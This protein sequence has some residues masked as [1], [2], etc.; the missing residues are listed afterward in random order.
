MLL[1]APC[2]FITTTAVPLGQVPLSIA[3]AP[4]NGFLYTGNFVNGGTGAIFGFTLVPDSGALTPLATSPYPMPQT[5]QAIAIDPTGKFGF[6]TAN[7]TAR[8]YVFSIAADGSWTQL[9]SSPTQVEI[10]SLPYGVAVWPLGSS[11]GGYVYTA[12]QHPGTISAFSYDSAGNL[13][14]LQGSPY[15]GGPQTQGIAIDPA[16]QFLYVA[17]FGDGTI[18]SFSIDPKTGIP[19]SLGA[20]VTTGSITPGITAPGPVDLKIDPSGRFLYCVNQLDGSVSHVQSAQGYF[21][22]PDRDVPHRQRSPFGRHRLRDDRNATRPP[23]LLRPARAQ[24]RT[25]G[26]LAAPARGRRPPCMVC[27]PDRR[28]TVPSSSACKAPWLAGRP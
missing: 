25:P 18:S 21:A 13:T 11:A 3:I 27:N 16:G 15:D 20:D 7:T 4:S 19:T 23:A 9:A 24:R 8:L 14:E 28:M 10:G 26:P 17:N 5:P 6:A 12:N 22:Y 1:A 2:R